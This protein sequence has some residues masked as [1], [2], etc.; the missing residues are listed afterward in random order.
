VLRAE[1]SGA[2][3]RPRL[4]GKWLT[5]GLFLLPALAL[6]LVFVIVPIIQAAHFSLFKWN[7]L[8]PLEDF[9]GLKNYQVALASDVFWTAVSNNVLII[10]LSLLIQIPFS[11]G[12]AILLN[13]RFPGRAIFRLLFFVPYVL[14]EA[15]TGIVFSLLLQPDALFDAG[16]KT[17][18][19]EGLVQEWLGNTD[20]VMLTMFVIITWKYFGFHMILLLAGLQ[21]IPREIE[22]AALIDGAGR[23]EAFRYVTLP[24]IGPTLRVSI[25]LSII[26]ALQLFDLV[27]VTT[28]G[29]PLNASTTMAVNMFKTGFVKQQMGYGSA[30]AVLLFMCA[31]VVALLYQR[32]VLR[33]DID[34]A[35]TASNG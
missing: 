6:Y 19:L 35:V 15:I 13:R 27:W 4:P 32:F 29:G 2:S 3:T 24:L 9:V 25:F 30:L 12:L 10:V 28:A 7:G 26:G 11:L 22:E 23:W 8:G 18:G 33:R 17:V 1:R 31:L 21:G 5:I 14:S 34:G 20:V 16:L